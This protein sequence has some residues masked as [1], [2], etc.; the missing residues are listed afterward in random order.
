M[1]IL[2]HIAEI[3]KEIA[4]LAG[5]S[6]GFVPT[7]GY[8]H[9]GHLSLVEQGKKENDLTVVSIFVNPAQFGPQEDFS[10]YPRDVAA[11]EKMLRDLDVDILFLPE[12]EEIYP[13][14]YLTYV[15]VGK[16]GGVLCGQ[17]RPG[18]FRGVATV[19]LKLFNIVTPTRAYFG[20]KDAQQATIIKKMVKDLDL[21]V[22]IRVMPIVRDPDGLALSSRN[23]YL[24]VTERQAALHLARGLVK[25]QAQ[26]AQ[27]LRGVGQIKAVIRKELENSD[28][29]QIDYIEVVSLDNLEPYA[30]GGN[31]APIDPGN[32]LVAAAI[33]VGRT[34]LIDNFVLG[35]I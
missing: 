5:Q 23:V 11:D 17:S 2:T 9:Q 4:R 33:N 16:L 20:Q 24:S 19:V 25:A 15:D 29:L 13:P 26:I 7:M 3:K 32:T 28:L 10:T 30:P 6:I 18:H 34:R 21:D 35:E 12:R 31:G 14:G 22:Q 8:L 27:G 1:K